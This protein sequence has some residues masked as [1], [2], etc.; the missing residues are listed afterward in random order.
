MYSY[1][2]LYHLAARKA[3]KLNKEL[4]VGGVVVDSH[5][6]PA[7]SPTPPASSSKPR[8]LDLWEEHIR[9]PQP[10][11]MILDEPYYLDEPPDRPDPPLKQI[12]WQPTSILGPVSV[13]DACRLYFVRVYG[14]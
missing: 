14:M 7:S 11:P 2:D 13:N 4:V 9:N 10:P 1:D 6:R 5:Q 3:Q 8:T 12:V